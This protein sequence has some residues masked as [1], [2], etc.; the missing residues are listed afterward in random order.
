M[1]QLETNLIETTWIDDEQHYF[2]YTNDEDNCTEVSED[3][4][5]I[6]GEY[7]YID[8]T[9]SSEYADS[10]TTE[11]DDVEE[12][13]V[14]NDYFEEHGTFDPRVRLLFQKLASGQTNL[15]PVD[16]EG[17]DD[18]LKITVKA[19]VLRDIPRV[20][21][22]TTKHHSVMFVA[23]AQTGKTF[24]ELFDVWKDKCMHPDWIVIMITDDNRQ[25]REQTRSR[26]DSFNEFLQTQFQALFLECGISAE[27]FNEHLALKYYSPATLP[28]MD[29]PLDIEKFLAETGRSVAIVNGNYVNFDR[30]YALSRIANKRFAITIDE[31]DTITAFGF[32]GNERTGYE[33]MIQTLDQ[34]AQQDATKKK[35]AMRY[36]LEC[37][38][39]ADVFRKWSLYTATPIAVWASSIRT[40]LVSR[41]SEPM[42]YRDFQ[43]YARLKETPDW[44]SPNKWDND[45]DSRFFRILNTISS[46]RREVDPSHLL[47]IFRIY[48]VNTHQKFLVTK[49]F[50][51]QRTNQKK[52]I[53]F[54]DN[55]SG[56]KH[57]IGPPPDDRDKGS[58]HFDGYA[59][60]KTVSGV[61]EFLDTTTDET[62]LQATTDEDGE[63]YPIL[64][65]AGHNAR[66]GVS[67]MSRS[68]RIKPN[69]FVFQ[70]KE[71]GESLV[72]AACR[73]C[74]TGGGD[75][76]CLFYSSKKTFER[77]HSHLKANDDWTAAM[78]K[79]SDPRPYTVERIQS[80]VVDLPSGEAV[81]RPDV[82]RAL[83]LNK[84]RKGNMFTYSIT[85]GQDEAVAFHILKSYAKS[86]HPHPEKLKFEVATYRY[87]LA[88]DS[89]PNDLVRRA[90]QAITVSHAD[91]M[92]IRELCLE[93]LHLSGLP[94]TADQ[95]SIHV[96]YNNKRRGHLDRTPFQKIARDQAPIY[97]DVT[98]TDVYPTVVYRNGLHS[99]KNLQPNTVYIIHQLDAYWLKMFITGPRGGLFN[100]YERTNTSQLF[101][102]TETKKRPYNRHPDPPPPKCQTK[103]VNTQ[104]SIPDDELDIWRQVVLKPYD[105]EI[106]HLDNV[107]P[108][109]MT[110]RAAIEHI[111]RIAVIR[112][113][114]HFIHSFHWM[115]RMI[116][117]NNLTLLGSQGRSPHQTVNTELHSFASSHPQWYAKQKDEHGRIIKDKWICRIE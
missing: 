22:Q 11:N 51:W 97:V 105:P 76:K 12:I 38:N 31:A 85:P 87:E 48:T 71:N 8:S 6:S 70:S 62:I 36:F 34:Q 58:T 7:E 23:R 77:I 44:P 54:L 46:S 109:S 90:T 108:H 96:A 5:G 1:A 14:H 20:T 37:Y 95:R 107:T 59:K 82:Q 18:R 30:L 113:G 81:T 25:I 99:T 68:G 93:A 24:M 69:F 72:Q 117:E 53:V 61:L 73:M 39:D 106:F 94:G 102:R 92:T 84:F 49:M 112:F 67:F 28:S 60:T 50:A 27:Y 57:W 83:M 114:R 19:S 116:R 66:R 3:S 52:F 33:I 65:V 40:A 32:V 26:V 80:V 9:T 17:D 15:Q 111:G 10:I 104:R 63:K 16:P 41:L 43:T 55:Q 91:S 103:R 89:I 78:V 35:M 64:I 98:Q 86:I 13:E 47:A 110:I 101:M 56:V 21:T 115:T 88:I 100:Q 2:I 45:A 42:D 75:T 79:R 74:G 4:D 29:K